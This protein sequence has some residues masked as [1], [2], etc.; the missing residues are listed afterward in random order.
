MWFV[1]DSLDKYMI[2]ITLHWVRRKPG[3]G[4]LCMRSGIERIGAGGTSRVTGG[5]VMGIKPLLSVI[6][7]K[8]RV[9]N[10]QSLV[11]CD[12]KSTNCPPDMNVKFYYQIG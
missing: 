10:T 2:T 6:D 8:Q 7:S 4:E 5:Q 3:N 9:D 11:V 1:T 12:I